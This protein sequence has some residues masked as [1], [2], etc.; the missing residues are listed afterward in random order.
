MRIPAA[1]LILALSATPAAAQAM[2]V[3]DLGPVASRQA[4]MTGARTVLERYLDAHGGLTVTGNPQAAEEWSVYG[5]ALRPGNSDVAILCPI[6][7]GQPH[8]FY[9]I[10]S[11]GEHAP[12]NAETAAQR[13]REFWDALR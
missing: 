8:A 1:C 7:A 4:C 3:G 6:V 2:K 12:A 5:W 9:S 11:S 13:L 10:H